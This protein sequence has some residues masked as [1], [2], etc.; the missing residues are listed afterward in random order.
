MPKEKSCGVV[1]FSRF[2]GIR[3]LLL[4][5]EE[6]HWDFPKGHVEEGETEEQAARRELQ[7][8]TGITQAALVQG[9]REPIHYFYRRGGKTMSKEVVFFLM[10]TPEKDVKISSEHIGYEWLPYDAALQR[11][12]F[13]NAKDVLRKAHL[14]LSHHT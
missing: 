12:T 7:E 1:L 6:G 4:H 5:Y 10:E 11:T 3:Y 14:A 13:K 2:A 8:E 9:F